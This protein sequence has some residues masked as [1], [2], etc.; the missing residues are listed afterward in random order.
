MEIY[1]PLLD[2]LTSSTTSSPTINDDMKLF[3][4][5]LNRSAKSRHRLLINSDDVASNLEEVEEKDRNG[6]GDKIA[7]GRATEDGD[8]TDDSSSFVTVDDTTKKD[9]KPNTQL[10]DT[11]DSYAKVV[12]DT[13]NVLETNQSL[14]TDSFENTDLRNHDGDT[15]L[16]PAITEVRVTKPTK[17]FLFGAHQ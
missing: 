15:I 13:Q 10:L 3:L 14:P 6:N 12:D 16:V 2:R 1:H 8:T 7:K 17:M 11:D 9:L 4:E 5:A